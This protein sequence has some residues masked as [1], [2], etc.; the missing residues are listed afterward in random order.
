MAEFALIEL[1]RERTAVERDD[2]R[3]GIGDDAAL[4]VVPAGAELVV[5]TDMMVAGVHFP[6]ATKPFDVGWKSLAVNLSDLAAMGATPAW[7]TLGLAMPVADQ[8]WVAAYAD[9]FAALARQFGLALVGGDTTRGPLTISVTVHGFV[10]V[11]MAL[12]RDGACVGDVV[13]VTGTL[14]DAAAGLRISL[15]EQGQSDDESRTLLDRLNR[16]VPRVDAGLALR[17]CATA[18]IDISDGLIADLGHICY[19]SQVGAEINSA[20][21]PSS[22]QLR[23]FTGDESHLSLQL[24]GGDD[25]ELCFTLPESSHSEILHRLH[26]T[27]IAATVIGRIV[28]GSGV[29]VSDATGRAIA[30][31]KSGWEHFSP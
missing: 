27:G 30:V 1:I 23:G 20:A 17:G 28:K 18:C 29:R 12:R 19:R 8:A 14:G 31:E 13:C 6:E 16:P 7:A 9:G 10:E 5:C 24:H 4:V 25:Y 15:A 21:L 3:L 2:V 11:G 26:S 22:A